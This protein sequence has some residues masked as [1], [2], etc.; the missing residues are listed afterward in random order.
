MN[1]KEIL[2][3]VQQIKPNKIM[4]KPPLLEFVIC[5]FVF[6]IIQ[7][8]DNTE[9]IKIEPHISEVIELS[10]KKQRKLRIITDFDEGIKM[11]EAENKKI[12]LMFTAL[13]CVNCRKLES[14]IIAKNKEIFSLMRDEFINVWLF[15]D[16]RN[17]DNREKWNWLQI[18][19]LQ[20]GTQPKMC[21]LN[22][23]GEK[24]TEQL[25]Y[26]EIEEF[27]PFLLENID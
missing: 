13:G 9:K 27:L 8:C 16:D 21:I 22:S 10:L 7:S 3:I 1:K 14:E 25:S 24:L 18:S 5:L 23:K 4:R 6:F 12:L 26:D 17:D 19:M 20:S 11:A 15:L 2:I